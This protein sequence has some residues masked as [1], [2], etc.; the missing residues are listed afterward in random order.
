MYNAK[1]YGEFFLGGPNLKA[2]MFQIQLPSGEFVEIAVTSAP[3]YLQSH[4][5]K[6]TQRVDISSRGSARSKKMVN[7]GRGGPKPG[8][9][10]QG[11]SFPPKRPCVDEDACHDLDLSQTPKR[12]FAITTAPCVSNIPAA[13][14]ITTPTAPETSANSSRDV[15][16]GAVEGEIQSDAVAEFSQI[17]PCVDENAC[18]DFN[19]AQT[20]KRHLAITTPPCAIPAASLDTTPTAAETFANSSRDLSLGI[21]EG[22]I[23]SDAVSE[24]SP[25]IL[26]S[27]Q[28]QALLQAMNVGKPQKL[29][30]PSIEVNH[31]HMTEFADSTSS[32]VSR[33]KEVVQEVDAGSFPNPEHEAGPADE[34]TEDGQTA[35]QLPIHVNSLKK[36]EKGRPKGS[37]NVVSSE[38]FKDPSDGYWTVHKCKSYPRFV[39]TEGHS[40][41]I[42]SH[43]RA[44]PTCHLYKQ[45]GSGTCPHIR[46]TGQRKFCSNW[47]EACNL[48]FHPTCHWVYHSQKNDSEFDAYLWLQTQNFARTSTPQ[49]QGQQN[50]I[51]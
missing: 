43:E 35:A 27:A 5:T 25:P 2:E 11:Q 8:R 20:P 36:G 46:M 42:Q 10:F 29:H 33:Q 31:Q 44:K 23:Q 48:C 19:V 21:M 49:M 4:K 32:E 14:L 9:G 15:S 30:F 13:C 24:F 1:K 17:R 39:V 26:K 50:V 22:E 16:L 38:T 41:K 37:K 45:L 18:N 51:S 12:R 47:C 7:E 3:H 6:T 28:R 40:G 34:A